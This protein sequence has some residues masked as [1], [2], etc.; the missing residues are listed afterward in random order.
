MSPS[1]G[2]GLLW[3]LPSYGHVNATADSVTFTSDDAPSQLDFWVCTTPGTCVS[4]GLS[5]ESDEKNRTLTP[6][7]RLLGLQSSDSWV[8]TTSATPATSATLATPAPRASNKISEPK[9]GSEAE[10][11]A[12]AEAG[13]EEVKV[14]AEAEAEAG[15]S[16]MAS[17]LHRYVDATGHAAPLPYYAT[18]FIQS[19]DRY[20]N[21]SQLL[22]VAREHV[23]TRGLP[24]SMIVIDF[25]HWAYLGDWALNAGGM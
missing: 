10:A 2:W 17:L 11:E 12:G 6:I 9:P 7:L 22:S 13:S 23:V 1:R 5:N 3:N 19:K 15:P 24:M 8:C 25:H 16:P 14:E 20:R 21:T 18:G 4:M